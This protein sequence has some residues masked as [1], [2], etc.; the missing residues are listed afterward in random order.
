MFV[1]IAANSLT[2]DEHVS[3]YDRPTP[4]R[5]RRRVALTCPRSWSTV[6]ALSGTHG[7]EPAQAATVWPAAR[8]HRQKP[9]ASEA[10]SS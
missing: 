1:V 10:R 7:A 9:N 5:A 2:P 6:V 3:L 8:R 4:D